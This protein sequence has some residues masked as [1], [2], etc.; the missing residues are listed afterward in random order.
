MFRMWMACS[1]VW[2]VGVYLSIYLFIYLSIYFKVCLYVYETWA[3]FGRIYMEHYL[4]IIIFWAL[5]FGEPD[6]SN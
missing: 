5:V 6:A 2:L 3:M 1:L 4:A